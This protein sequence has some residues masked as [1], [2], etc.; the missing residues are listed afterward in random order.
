MTALRAVL[1]MSRR[2]LLRNKGRSALAFAMITLPVL[3][4]VALAVLWRTG[5]WTPRESL[6]YELGHADARVYAYTREPVLQDPELTSSLPASTAGVTGDFGTS[7]GGDR[8]WSAEEVR[9]ALVSRYGPG[10]TIAPVVD[11]PWAEVRT[12]RGRIKA[13]VRMLD[14]R[15]PLA[16]GMLRVTDGRPPAAAGEVTVSTALRD[17][18]FRIG[19]D[20][21]IDQK[22]TRRRIVGV[23]AD[24][25][26][27]GTVLL[28]ALPIGVPP[29]AQSSWLVRTGRPMTWD[30]VKA[31]NR[32]GI[33]ALSRAV[34][35][36]PPSDVPAQLRQPQNG[37]E[38]AIIAMIFA[39]ILLQVVLL[40]GPAFAVGIRRQRRRLA[41]V[42]ANGGD[43]RW[44]RTIVLAEGGLVGGAAAVTGAVL[45]IVLA[46]VVKVAVERFSDHGLGPFEVPLAQVL[47]TMALGA[48]SGL[49]AAYMPARQAA[50]M[51]VVAAL[52]GRRDDAR[53]AHG[54]PV[55]GA[56][57]LA[58]GLFVSLAGVKSL[59]EFGAAVGAVLV[60]LGAVLL[61]PLAVALAGRFAAPLPLPLRLA[62]RD[63]ARNGGRT[64]PAVAAVLAAV[65]AATALGVGSSSDFAQRRMEYVPRLPHGSAMV[66]LTQV[67]RPQQRQKIREA[68][69]T[70]LPGV[71]VTELPTLAEMAADCGT[72]AKGCLRLRLTDGAPGAAPDAGTADAD[73]STGE[74]GYVV[75]GAE[76]ARLVL[77][78][79]VPEV[80]AALSA[81]KVVLLRDRPLR[82]G[83]VTA[84]VVKEVETGSEPVRKITVPATAYRASLPTRALI[85]PRVADRLK[86]STGTVLALDRTAHRTTE[87][88]QRRVNERLAE[89]AAG[90]ELYVERGPTERFGTVL[91]LLGGAA[92]V[93][94]LGGSLI[95]T[96]LSAADSRPDL[97]TLAAVGAAPRTRRWLTMGQA[98]CVA[99]LGTWLGILSGM[100][101]GIAAAVPLTAT[102]DGGAPPG[103]R[104]HGAV[105]DIP[106]QFL[107]GVG[108]LVPLT[109]MLV[110]GLFTR[111]RLTTVRRVAA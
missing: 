20:I 54:K 53:A 69:G 45:G 11:A 76:Q 90:P 59:R 73:Q 10:T 91:L 100:V 57:L 29:E 50:R 68:I 56:V 107:M 3:A 84:T 19:S 6:P 104:L 83:K 105:I 8:P 31:L 89:V 93:L 39:M 21:E 87:S 62:V 47:A 70:E 49:A 64:A 15:D 55:L 36:D 94:V 16:R 24:P 110:A 25:R 103:V 79:D 77:G 32:M 12:G 9:A 65:A 28:Q 4:I 78:R 101:P 106:W 38:T 18:G 41:L 81:G 22:G 43:R 44:L 34:V 35:E 82:E 40:A 27:P 52:G 102:A 88:E 96:G 58:A 92:A 67:G 85:P 109:A 61:T 1:R 2:E 51:N 42:A 48:L 30:E 23:V 33:T 66:D 72:S 97:A 14:L 80:N 5:E 111:S 99:V 75:G 63:A 74:L 37:A 13:E 86:F 108:V 71:P 98:G 95:A 26:A 17:L 60:I 7:G 46:A